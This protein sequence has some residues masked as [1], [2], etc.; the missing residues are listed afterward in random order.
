MLK[1]NDNYESKKT[2]FFGNGELWEF[3]E[4]DCH[5]LKN[6]RIELGMTQ[7]QVADAAHIQVRQYQRLETGE[8][9]MSGASMR[10]GLSIC[11]VLKLDPFRFYFIPDKNNWNEFKFFKIVLSEFKA[12]MLV[13]FKWKK[14]V[15]SLITHNLK[16]NY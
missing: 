1:F 7:Q 12:Q 11:S 2:D 5:I 15:N 8:R 14:I 13:W 3:A 16:P 9:S 10:I 4:T 6:R